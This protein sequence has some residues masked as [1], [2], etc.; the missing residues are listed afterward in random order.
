MNFLIKQL[1]VISPNL[2]NWFLMDSVVIQDKKF[3]LFITHDEIEI[4]VQVMAENLN[5]DLAGKDVVF[6][7]VLNGAFMFAADLLKKITLK[8]RMSFVKFRSYTGT[9]SSGV[10]YEL[11]GLEEDLKGKTVVIV[12]DIIDSGLTIEQ[13]RN[14]LMKNKPSEIKI[15]ALLIK[16]ANHK[17]KVKIDYVGFEIPD[18][19]I[20]G[21]GLDYNGYGRQ[22]ENIYTLTD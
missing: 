17:K 18:E 21:Y 15:A 12:E 1:F 22:L 11:I 16:P 5:K 9:S 3:N 2:Q 4:A 10:V 19:F 14:L 7:T 20:I 8:C 13:V 6:L